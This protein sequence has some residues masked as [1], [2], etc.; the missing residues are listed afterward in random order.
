MAVKGEH[1]LEHI[2]ILVKSQNPE[3]CSQGFLM[4]HVQ[5]VMAWAVEKQS[6]ACQS[7]PKY[8]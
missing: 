2:D 8:I 7:E 5:Q 3:W 1:Q 4:M 6:T